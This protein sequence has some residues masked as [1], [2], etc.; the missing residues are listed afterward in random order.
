MYCND[1]HLGFKLI[2]KILNI[3]ENHQW[4]VFIPPFFLPP[5][6]PKIILM[7]MIIFC[8]IGCHLSVSDVEEKD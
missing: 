5:F 1:G 4:I 8:Q 3:V 6:F 2:K 7:Y